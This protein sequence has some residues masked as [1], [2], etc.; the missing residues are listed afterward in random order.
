MTKRYYF[1]AQFKARVAL[2]ALR[3]DRMAESYSATTRCTDRIRGPISLR[4]LLNER[5]PLD[6]LQAA[7]VT[8]ASVGAH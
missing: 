7:L 1:A 5:P 3:G 4:E 8:S 6:H 2:D